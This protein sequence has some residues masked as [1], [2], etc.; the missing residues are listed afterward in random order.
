MICGGEGAFIPVGL[1]RILKITKKNRYFDVD[2][3]DQ[4]FLRRC[5]RIYN[6]GVC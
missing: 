3:S 1:I 4:D 5:R 2:C 6:R